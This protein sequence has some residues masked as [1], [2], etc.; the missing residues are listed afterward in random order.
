[1]PQ[2]VTFPKWFSL[3]NPG[4]CC[5]SSLILSCT[6]SCGSGL[7]VPRQPGSSV[8]CTLCCLPGILSAATASDFARLIHK[9]AFIQTRV[10]VERRVSG[11][12]TPVT[13][14]NSCQHFLGVIRPHL[15]SLP[16]FFFPFLMEYLGANPGHCLVSLG[17]NNIFN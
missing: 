12:L 16:C 14:C 2:V 5:F 17:S 10:E 15:T 7:K 3:D 6:V 1:M 4:N 13:R 8:F 11:A 9:T